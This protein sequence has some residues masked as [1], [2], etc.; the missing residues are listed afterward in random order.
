MDP[1]EYEIG[2]WHFSVE[3]GA[4]LV[5][6][7]NEA[8]GQAFAIPADQVADLIVGLLVCNPGP[9]PELIASSEMARHFD[10]TTETI[11]NWCKAGLV[12]GLLL[13]PYVG[14]GG[15][16]YNRYLMPKAALD[17]VKRPTRGN[18][19]FGRQE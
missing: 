15:T 19:N 17:E 2:G 8:T 14:P 18:P 3:P 11:L 16:V 6:V 4:G 1:R 10:V 9:N 5:E 7:D 13:A 12:P